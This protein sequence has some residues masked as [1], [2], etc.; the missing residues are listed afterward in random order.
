LLDNRVEPPAAPRVRHIVETL[1]L[2]IVM[3]RLHPR[4]RLVEG[5]LAERFQVS[6][7][8]VRTALAE[9]ERRALIVRVP[10]VGAT[11]VDLQ[12]DQVR[13]LYE[14]REVVETAVVGMIRLPLPRP[15][16]DRLIAAQREHDA[17]VAARDLRRVFETNIRFHAEMNAL[18]GNPHLIEMLELLAARSHVVRS[19]SH[20]DPAILEAAARNHWDMIEAIEQEDRDRLVELRR[21]HL[22][23]SKNAYIRA[24]RQRF[25]EE[26]ARS[27]PAAAHEA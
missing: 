23:P 26:A 15:V 1:E 19:Y 9:F 20:S 24:Y 17:A 25:P 16:I 22:Q 4:E 21:A 2:D 12:P 11:V 6:R 27:D 10:N 3:M 5:A 14:A 7:A 18:C 8:T 13:A